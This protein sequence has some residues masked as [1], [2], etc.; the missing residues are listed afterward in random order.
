MGGAYIHRGKKGGAQL[1]LTLTCPRAMVM[2]AAEV[3]PL[4]TGTG[5]KSTRNPVSITHTIHTQVKTEGE[6]LYSTH[7]RLYYCCILSY[8]QCSGKVLAVDCHAPV[9][10]PVYVTPISAHFLFSSFFF[11]SYLVFLITCH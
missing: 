1:S 7:T 3:K 11:C 2:A 5:M 6:M 4:M 8:W 9:A 10:K